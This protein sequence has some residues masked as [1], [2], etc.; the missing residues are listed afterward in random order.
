PIR[1]GLL[2]GFVALLS[3]GLIALAVVLGE[4]AVAPIAITGGA[5]LAVAAIFGWL[6][7]S[8]L[9]RPLDRLAL[10]IWIIAR[11]NPGHALGIGTRHWLTRLSEGIEAMRA[12]LATVEAHAAEALAEARHQ[13]ADQKRWL[14]AILHDLTEGIIVC[15][16]QQQVLL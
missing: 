15:N 8:R 11:E 1:G 14:E 13:E 6:L 3:P 5:L 2:F 12:R 7:L 9:A 10:D 4:P 16:L